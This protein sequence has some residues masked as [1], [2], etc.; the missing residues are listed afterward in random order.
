M[1]TEIGLRWV[2]VEGAGTE[3]ESVLASATVL[4]EAEPWAPSI[5]ALQ[6]KELSFP[7]SVW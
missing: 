1:G 2:W 7:V 5:S 3:V 6:E 4:L